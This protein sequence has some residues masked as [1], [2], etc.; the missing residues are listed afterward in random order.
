[1]KTPPFALVLVLGATGAIEALGFGDGGPPPRGR[2]ALVSVTLGLEDLAASYLVAGGYVR[3]ASDLRLLPRPRLHVDEGEDAPAPPLGQAALA[4]FVVSR[5]D[6]AQDVERLLSAPVV[7]SVMAFLGEATLGAGGSQRGGWADDGD[8]DVRPTGDLEAACDAVRT[9]ELWDGAVEMLG[10]VPS[11]FRASCVMSSSAARGARSSRP[12]LEAKERKHNMEDMYDGR[13]VAMALGG[14]VMQSRG[15]GVDLYNYDAEVYGF[16]WDGRL[17]C[18]LLLGG[19]WRPNR[20]RSGYKF[21]VAPFCEARARPYR[22]RDSPSGEDDGGDG[23]GAGPEGGGGGG[24]ATTPWYMPKLRPSTALLLLLLS[25]VGDGDVVLDPMGGSGTVA[26][27]AAYHFD[28]DATSSDNDRETTS[29][30]VQAVVEARPHLVGR[31]IVRDLDA[32]RLAPSRDNDREDARDGGPIPQGSIDR[33]V[34]DTPFGQRCRWNIRR[35]LPLVLESIGHVLNPS[36]GRAV[37]LMKGY[38]RLEGLVAGQTRLRLVERREVNIG[39]YLCYALV[40]AHSEET[41][42]P[43]GKETVHVHACT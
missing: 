12:G 17:T 28:V 9:S 26:I 22:V 15:W 16:L 5:V 36:G 38:R 27:E 43:G 31:C 23:K 21:S 29:A 32:T 7:Q 25:G 2:M 24:G 19:E 20:R 30:A 35:E 6:A 13:D 18:G 11:T 14:G 33:I 3:D 8:G 37:L 40:L 39:G 10:Y 41:V 42:H 4:Q 34:A 1:M